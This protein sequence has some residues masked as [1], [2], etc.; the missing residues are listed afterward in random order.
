MDT[1]F[2][3]ESGM[4]ETTKDNTNKYKSIIDG[5]IKVIDDKGKI[6]EA[7]T[8]CGDEIPDIVEQYLN[9][10]DVSSIEAVS[11][12]D[13]IPKLG[14]SSESLFMTTSSSI[15][16][17]LISL[18]EFVRYI[19]SEGVSKVFITNT[20]TSEDYT[21]EIDYYTEKKLAKYD[22]D[23]SDIELLINDFIRQSNIQ[24]NTFSFSTMGGV[25]I[26]YKADVSFLNKVTSILRTCVRIL[27]EQ[28]EA[29]KLE[30]Y[31]AALNELPMLL[32]YVVNDNEYKQCTNNTKRKNYKSQG[33]FL[34]LPE[35]RNI[36]EMVNNKPVI[37]TEEYVKF[38]DFYVQYDALFDIAKDQIYSRMRQ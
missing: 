32:E 16:F 31:E 9:E 14:V 35:F 15:R 11:Y 20:D 19:R 13:I 18:E 24:I 23:L 7:N 2:A 10:L 26:T 1:I 8:I 22:C 28:D 4:S 12:K 6:I 25:G 17:E 30:I 36:K 29:E 27:E 33:K 3:I 37:N 21:Y 5:N 38:R 34:S